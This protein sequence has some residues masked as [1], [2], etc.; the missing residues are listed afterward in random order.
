MVPALR[1]SIPAVFTLFCQLCWH[2]Q[3]ILWVTLLMMAPL[4]L[5]TAP[6]CFDTFSF[7]LWVRCDTLWPCTPC[8]IECSSRAVLVPST[9]LMVLVG[10]AVSVLY[11][12]SFGWLSKNYWKFFT[13]LDHSSQIRIVGRSSI[14]VRSPVSVVP[15]CR[16][17]VLYELLGSGSGWGTVC[18]SVRM[19]NRHHSD[20]WRTKDLCWV[21]DLCS[22]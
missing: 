11:G 8:I 4:Q 12:R 7:P 10:R 21:D 5:R 20:R 1:S 16:K 14:A 2:W 22:A 3:S 18:E 13:P 9:V 6:A 15:S 19:S 17:C